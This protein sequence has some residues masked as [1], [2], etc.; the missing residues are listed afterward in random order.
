[1]IAVWS[2]FTFWLLGH[3]LLVIV[4]FGPTFTF[5]GIAA[6]ARKDPAHA[7]AYSKVIHFVEQRMT[8]PLAVLVPLFGTGLIYTGHIDLWKSEWL[9]ISIVLFIAAFFFALLVQLPNSTKMVDVLTGM[10]PGPPPPGAQ[11]PAEVADLGKKLQFGGMY[12]TASVL[13]ILIL[14]IWQPGASFT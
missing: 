12:L 11:P 2:W 5:P 7:I 10:P 1:M 14:M 8:L 6:M 9:V 13:V 3:I 4:A